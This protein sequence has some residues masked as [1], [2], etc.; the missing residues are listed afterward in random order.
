VARKTTKNNILV[1][2]AIFLAAK[3]KKILFLA[4]KTMENNLIFGAFLAF[5]DRQK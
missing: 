1:F 3:N 5:D 2:L 4:G